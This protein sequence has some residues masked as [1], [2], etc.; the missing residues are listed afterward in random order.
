[1]KIG[2]DIRCLMEARYSGISEYAYNLIN[3]LLKIDQKNQYFLFYN[4]NK[5]SKLPEFNYPN[6][7][8]CGFHYPNKIFNLALRFLKIAKVDKMIGGVD[9]FLIPNF[10]FL[11]LSK[12]C[13]K[14]LIIHDLSFELYPEFF[15]LKTRLWHKLIGPKKM[16]EQADQI[17]A[18]SENTKNDI[19]KI[20][21]INPA[22]IKVIYPGI[23]EIFFQPTGEQKIAKIKNK[24]SL[25][26]DY[27][28]YLGNLEPRKNVQTLILAFEKMANPSLELVIAGTQAWKYKTMYR[29]WQKSKFK[30][31]IKFLGYVDA[32][33]KPALYAGAKM[34]VY[35]SIYEGFGLPPLEAMA[36]G[37]PV[38]TSFNSSLVEA[39]DQA[40]L[41]VDPNNYNELA[42]IM[43]KLLADQ[44]LQ[45]FLKA[46]GIKRSQQFN[47]PKTSQQILDCLK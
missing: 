13:K 46:K 40:G 1:M 6:V 34:F 19:V 38:I 16:C 2:V 44:K 43:T 37:T 17:I 28:F 32:A 3:H 35:P 30:D 8:F 29:L 23:S 10:L 24:F 15:T 31:Q 27:I 9:V 14:V 7:K 36:S 11:N 4:S 25:N 39:V 22:K 33:D 26:Q 42:Q 12:D 20:Y 18:I 47:W 45:D 21:G 5:V 41:L